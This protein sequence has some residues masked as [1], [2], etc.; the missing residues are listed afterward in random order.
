MLLPIQGISPPQ[1][2]GKTIYNEIKNK[3][4]NK[5]EIK[6]EK[7]EKNEKKTDNSQAQMQHLDIRYITVR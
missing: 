1:N 5:E 3:D 2:T 6:Q 7:K 4:N